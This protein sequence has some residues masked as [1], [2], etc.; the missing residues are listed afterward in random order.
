MNSIESL[1]TDHRII[2]R[3]INILET[4]INR[5]QHGISVDKIVFTTLIRFFKTFTDE[6]HHAKEEEVLFPELERSGIQKGGGPIAVML[7]EHNMGR[8]FLNN[9]NK[10]VE[11]YY[12][13]DV[14]AIQDIIKK[15][16][17][18]IDLLRNHILKEEN[19][20]FH[21]A[22]QVLDAKKDAELFEEFEKV[23][24]EKIGPGKHEELERSIEDLE[25]MIT[26]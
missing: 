11:K 25:K 4:S 24:N 26:S 2:E 8:V 16:S 23:E 18:Y 14:N 22:L 3:A 5:L 10:A 9:L 13:G 21:I 19:I 15:S 12:S 17:D 1:K 20:L 6:C 7:Y